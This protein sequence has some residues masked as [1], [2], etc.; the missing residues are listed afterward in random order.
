MGILALLSLAG[1]WC[2]NNWK[3]VLVAAFAAWVGWLYWDNGHLH[4]K[5]N[6]LNLTISKI[7]AQNSTL[8]S[9]SAAL[10]AEYS[11]QLSKKWDIQQ[12]L[13]QSEAKRIQ[14]EKILRNYRLPS[15]AVRVF[16]NTDSTSNSQTTTQAKQGNDGGTTSTSPTVTSNPNEPSDKTLADLLVA[17]NENR[18]RLLQCIDTVH[19]WQHFWIDFSNAVSASDSGQ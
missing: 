17:A 6:D 5:I 15:V 7:K 9:A 4:R 1:K 13:A 14:D 8:T 10:T 11:D 18:S 3:L 12:K 2:L 19:E 16:N